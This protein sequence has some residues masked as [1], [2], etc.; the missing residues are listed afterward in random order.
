MASYKHGS[1]LRGDVLLS[2]V[3]LFLSLA[4]SF[5]LLYSLFIR[6]QKAVALYGNIC[7]SACDRTGLSFPVRTDRESYAGEINI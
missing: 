2:L 5:S 3:T 7:D 6:G 1:L 4:L